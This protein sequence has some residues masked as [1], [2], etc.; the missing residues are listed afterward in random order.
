[1]PS[2]PFEV[3]I[4]EDQLRVFGVEVREVLRV[5]PAEVVVVARDQVLN[6]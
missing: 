4:A 3:P 1:M 6:L 5:L 2:L